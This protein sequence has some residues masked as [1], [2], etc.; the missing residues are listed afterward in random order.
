MSELTRQ[1]LASERSLLLKSMRDADAEHEAGE[2][3]DDAHAAIVERDRARIAAIE[4]TLAAFE[5]DA[6]TP[7]PEPSA[8]V[9]GEP[10]P[11]RADRG[12][13]DGP[14]RRR[15]WLRRN[16]LV[17]GLVAVVVALSGVIVVLAVDR[18]SS[19]SSAT[20]IATLLNTAD[21]DVQ[22]GKIA[23]ALIAYT[24]VLSTDPTQPH[25]LAQAGWLS[26]EAGAES[27]STAVMERGEAEV[28]SSVAAD[29]SLFAGHLYL[30]AIL[31]LSHDDPTGALSEFKEFLALKP[32]AT[33]V[34]KA[35]PYLAK[36]ASEAGV[37]VPTTGS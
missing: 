9:I 3:G 22:Q 18:S 20:Q 33:W 25:A 8:A 26:Y 16:R 1:R 11:G 19:P 5:V 14:E 24:K 4:A 12:P 2:L 32:P 36:A 27:G 6:A 7:S 30:G 31:L 29:P 37:P 23:E 35:Q 34:K 10:E 13:D 21:N 28:R 15:T 17:V